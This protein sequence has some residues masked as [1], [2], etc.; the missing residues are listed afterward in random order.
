[1]NNKSGAFEMSVG[2][3]VTIVL[4][5]SLL[6]L[7]IFFVQRIFGE[8]EI[9][10]IENK[11]STTEICINTYN[12]STYKF[13]EN[14]FGELYEVYLN[15]SEIVKEEEYCNII[16]I[17]VSSFYE[18]KLGETFDIRS[19]I[20]SE[21]LRNETTCEEVEVDRMLLKATYSNDGKNVAYMI[22]TKLN[23][24]L[25]IDWLDENA[26]CVTCWSDKKDIS[27]NDGECNERYPSKM[28]I[29]LEYKI[30]NYSIGVLK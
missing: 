22:F 28:E 18:K 25:T 4:S 17:Y 11:C 30:G 5:V 12:E 14:E 16:G 19:F 26:K 20:S 29:C 8:P 7:G 2:T 27:S 21:F 15:E 6:V 24:D 13:A 3:I 9:K 10:I 1:M 23:E